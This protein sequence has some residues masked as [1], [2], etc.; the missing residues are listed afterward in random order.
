MEVELT[1][2]EI[3]HLLC[4]LEDSSYMYTKYGTRDFTWEENHE[5]VEKKLKGVIDGLSSGTANT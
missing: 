3:K 5:A 1:V 2:T 4:A